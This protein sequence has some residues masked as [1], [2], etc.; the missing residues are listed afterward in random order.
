MLDRDERDRLTARLHHAVSGF[1]DGPRRAVEEAD[2]IFEE[3]ARHL[4]DALTHRRRV[5]REPW[6][7]ARHAPGTPGTD[8]GAPSGGPGSA[9]AAETEELRL[10]LRQYKEATERLLRL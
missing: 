8:S 5:L 1:V 3:A 9:S 2:G 4:E 6:Q 10:A 7:G